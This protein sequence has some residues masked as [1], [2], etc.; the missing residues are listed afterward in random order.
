[1]AL[2]LPRLRISLA[3]SGRL[4]PLDLFP[5]TVSG[6]WLEIGFG[7]GEHI[8]SLAARNPYI[9]II[10]AEPFVNGVAKLLVAIDD[11]QLANIR[12]FD[13]DGRILLENLEDASIDRLFILY[14]DPWPK[15]RHEKRRLLD[16]GTVA[17]IYRV[18]KPGGELRLASDS[19]DYIGW[20]LRNILAHGGFDWL[21]QRPRDWRQPPGDW[22]Q[23][24]YETKA[25]SDGRR[26]TYLRFLRRPKMLAISPEGI[27]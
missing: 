4:E 10:G 7:G 6:I 22:C 24:R 27:I 13:G 16:G 19:A 21:A 11:Q 1:M 25:L 14:P 17:E 3:S 9:G 23:T 26:P 2:L 8:V 15:R 12:I 5:D 18:M 20:S